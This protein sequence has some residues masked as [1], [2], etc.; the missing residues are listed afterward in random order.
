MKLIEK[1]LGDYGML[2]GFLHEYN[3]ELPNITK[4][5][6]VIILPGGG[7]RT[8]S[9]REAE[10][11]AMAYYAAGYQAFVVN[12]T[13]TSV[14]PNAL[15]AD[16]M[17]DVTVALDYIRAN[18]NV[19]LVADGKLAMIG[20]SG[21]GHLAAAV[22]THG[23]SRPDALLLGY[24]G[25]LPSNLRSLSCNDILECVDGSTP[26]AFLFSMHGDTITPPKHLLSFACKL[27]EHNIPFELHM[28]HGKGHGLSL[29]TSLTCAGFSS[30][31]NPEY[32][33]W[34]DMSVRWLRDLFGDFTI[35]GVND[36]R[37]GKF[38]I[39]STL[40]KLFSDVQ[41]KQICLQH[42]PALEK[43]A[44]G[45]SADEFT[46]RRIN[47]FMPVLTENALTAFDQALLSL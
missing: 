16:S 3:E 37:S 33:T 11:V 30:D 12:Y 35:Y 10:P 24:P 15:I 7:F 31:I 14:K 20:F 38:S 36:G 1:K 4:Y 18:K 23:P 32:G 46:P 42:M 25:I 41:A 2:T 21:G 13:V 39:D 34:F 6:A 40:S 28:F 47:S 9:Y 43:F 45:A 29:G 27:E 17:N 22:A 19:L 8:C 44:A 5:P 26:P